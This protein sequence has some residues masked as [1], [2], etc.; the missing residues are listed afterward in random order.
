MDK[1]KGIVAVSGSGMDLIISKAMESGDVST[2]EKLLAMN[3]RILA[4]QAEIA[5]N[6]AMARLQKKLPI[7]HQ[8]SQIK[9][10]DKIIAKYAKYEDID[11]QIRGLYVEEGFSLSYD[12]KKLPDGSIQYTGKVSHVNGHSVSAEIILPADESGAK[13]KVQAQGSSITYAKRYLLTMLLNLVFTGEDDD[14]QSLTSPVEENMVDEIELLIE[15]HGVDRQKFLEFFKV[16]EV[17]DL[18]QKDYK[19]AITMLKAKGA[20]K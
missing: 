16:T 12:S 8:A 4:K 20:K 19:R 11:R 3:E 9:H 15:K 7:I 5:F 10:G 18:P 1:E 13:N 2:L 14:A 6:E 17:S